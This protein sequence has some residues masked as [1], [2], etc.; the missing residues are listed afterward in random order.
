MNQEKII[1]NLNKYLDWHNLPIRMNE[2]GVCNGIATVYAKY[3]LEHREDEFLM[4]LEQIALLNPNDEL[5]SQ[6]NHFATEVVLSF[7]LSNLTT[8]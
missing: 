6:V 2:S 5:A 3:V 8:N 4:M 7:C 1:T